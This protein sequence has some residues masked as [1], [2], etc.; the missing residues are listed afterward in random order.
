MFLN[1][2]HLNIFN[3]LC[4]DVREE[5]R[6]TDLD[7]DLNLVYL[8]EGTYVKKKKAYNRKENPHTWKVAAYQVQTQVSTDMAVGLPDFSRYLKRCCRIH[9]LLPLIFFLLINDIL[10]TR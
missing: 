8:L 7:R 6:T 10:S 3:D 2:P 1:S 4:K 5:L 9:S